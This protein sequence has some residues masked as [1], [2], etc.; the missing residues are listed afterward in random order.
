MINYHGKLVLGPM[1]RSGELPTRLLALKYGADLVWGPEIIDKK[2]ITCRR[3]ENRK[4][5]TIEYLDPSNKI[6]FNTYKPR[7]Q[8]KLIFQIGSSNPD[9]AVEAALKVIN[10]VDGIDLNCGCPKPFS[11]HAGMGAALLSTPNLLCDIL[12][13]LV[14]KVGTPKNKPI[15]CKIR[16]LPNLQDTLQLVEDICNTGIKNLTLHCRTRD[17]RNYQVPIHDYINDILQITN[18]YNISLIINGNLG[19]YLDFLELSKKYGSNISGMICESAEANPSVFSL[20]PLPWRKLIL[21]FLTICYKFN[22]HPANTKYILL[23]QLPPKSK[24]YQMFARLK[25][26]RQMLDLALEI[27]TH[28]ETDKFDKFDFIKYR[29]LKKDRLISVTEF[30]ELVKNLDGEVKK[31]KNN[32]EEFEKLTELDFDSLKEPT[33]KDSI[34]R[35]LSIKTLS[36]EAVMKKQMVN[37]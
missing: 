34:K 18:K 1:V 20:N 28:T 26:N 22:N 37:I 25:T 36:N 24:Y 5:D 4:L 13:N 8:S 30:N 23:N 16:L 29:R 14:I 7:E 35:K 2:L 9:T 27:Q 3:L 32:D 19:Y 31:P 11:V 10:D 33:E 6:I 21:E 15:S 12:S 17:M